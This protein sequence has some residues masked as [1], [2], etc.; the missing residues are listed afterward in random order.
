M[1][2]YRRA[3]KPTSVFFVCK[4]GVLSCM[5]AIL[6]KCRDTYILSMSVTIP[7][8]SLKIITILTLFTNTGYECDHLLLCYH[9]EG[10]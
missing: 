4:S 10:L 9:D 7:L 8:L 5:L 2:L 1:Q 6:I 3:Y